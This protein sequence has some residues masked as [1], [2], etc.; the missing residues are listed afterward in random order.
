M[1]PLLRTVRLSATLLIGLTAGGFGTPSAQGI[2]PPDMVSPTPAP[3][4]PSPPIHLI[5]PPVVPAR[6]Q[7]SPELE[8]L[9]L[10]CMVY[11]PQRR[12]SLEQLRVRVEEE[13]KDLSTMGHGELAPEF[14]EWGVFDESRVN[15]EDKRQA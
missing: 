10:Q 4:P 9:A 6:G 5:P 13:Y 11:D 3:P 7:Y 2:Y 14:P 1:T 8:D 15:K 12:M